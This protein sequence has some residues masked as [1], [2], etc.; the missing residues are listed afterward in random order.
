MGDMADFYGRYLDPYEAEEELIKQEIV[1]NLLLCEDETIYNECKQLEIKD[2]YEYKDL[3]EK[4]LQYYE[5][6]KKLTNNQKYALCCLLAEEG[7]C[8]LEEN[9]NGN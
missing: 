1:D 2:D 4:I 3:C 6:Y 5:K 8:E 7:F 9:A